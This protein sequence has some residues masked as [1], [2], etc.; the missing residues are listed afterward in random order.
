MEYNVEQLDARFSSCNYLAMDT[1]ALLLEE[2]EALEYD[3]DIN[4]LFVPGPILSVEEKNPELFSDLAEVPTDARI[5]ADY[6]F[7]R[8]VAQNSCAV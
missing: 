2:Q 5:E 1:V 7:I 6:T 3:F 8:E 4:E